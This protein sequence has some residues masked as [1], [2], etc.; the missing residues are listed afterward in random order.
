MKKTILLATAL[1]MSFTAMAERKVT[2]IGGD[3]SF[4]TI[5]RTQKDSL[6]AHPK[7]WTKVKLPHTWNAADGQDGGGNYVRGY[8]WYKKTLKVT[9]ESSKIYTLKFNGACT[10]ATVY[11]NNVE[12]G[13]HSG[14][15]S[16][17]SFDITNYL[18]NGNNEILV[19]VDNREALD[20]APVSAD[21]TFYGGIHRT[22]ELIE[23][24][25]VHIT[26]IDHAAPGVYITQKKVS[27]A[28]ADLNILAKV[29][30]ASNAN[31]AVTVTYI[32]RDAE[33]KTVATA[34]NSETIN[35]GAT[36][37]VS[38]DRKLVAPTLWNGQK[39]PY[40]YS[41]E[42]CVKDG[43]TI[44]DSV[45]QP[46]GVRDI[47]LTTDG[48]FL[49]GV[50]TPLR[51]VAI[52]EERR[53]KGRAL[54]NDD[55]KED[56]DMMIEMGC[57]YLR[58][59]HY[60]HADFTYSYCD[61]MGIMNWAEIPVI[62]KVKDT[63]EFTKTSKG[64][65]IDLIRQNYN[66]PSIVVWGICNEINYKTFE[67]RGPNPLP[68]VKALNEV[69][70][71][72][73]ATRPSVLAAM[74]GEPST[75]TNWVPDAFACNHYAGW[76]YDNC[77]DF[78]TFYDDLCAK[79]PQSIIGISEYGCGANIE[80]HEE[81]PRKPSNPGGPF[82][83]EEYQ[84][85]F[86]EVHLKA[87]ME[88]PKM[89][90]SSVWAAFDFSSDGRAEGSLPGVN[91]KGLVTQDRKVKKDA[92]FLYQAS[93]TSKPMVYLTSRRFTTREQ[94]KVNVKAYSNCDEVE[95]FV[96]GV[97]Q[98]K[99]KG[100]DRAFRWS[101]VSLKMGKNKI[102]V[103]G[104]KGDLVL[105]DSAVWTRIEKPEEIIKSGDI[106][107]NFTSSNDSL[108][109]YL[110]DRGG[111]FADRGKGYTY[112][113]KVPNFDNSRRRNAKDV[114]ERFL[115]FV[116]MTT[117]AKPNEWE[118]ALPNGKYEVTIGAGDVD[119]L[120]SYNKIDAEKVT[121]LDFAPSLDKKYSAASAIVEVLDGKLTISMNKDAKN[122]KLCF[123]NISTLK[124][125]KTKK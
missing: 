88:R 83:S 99:V 32:I 30:N 35:A 46:L 1:L 72:E 91:D 20:V 102:V 7:A 60:Q 56:V 100:V 31:K 33:G 101:D 59:S 94:E 53:D 111:V 95:L 123:V 63:E 90:C 64:Q 98:G 121:V 18:K 118:I 9:K 29:R 6:N 117:S 96:N 45:T 22:V 25:A 84:N 19:K 43:E 23:T 66:H 58:L 106:Q 52:H 70:K 73:D 115:G 108:E 47:K 37:N 34:S 125:Y 39:N 116:H 4:Y 65:L 40:L 12:V 92:Y 26:T 11:I 114:E 48:F 120:D 103:K 57:N 122:A 36:K 55:R 49:N 61:K 74:Y 79:Y 68:L 93:W 82:H 89:W 17:F 124:V 62:N 109:G 14:G 27:A 15:Y 42:V 71:S 110:A 119:Y 2:T 97:S 112:G 51:G 113:W 41:V 16:A 107:I 85:L 5:N 87:I 8:F 21:F 3:W 28:S 44:L 104:Y 76:Y 67:E 24:D 77:E 81:I 13:K 80:H 78:A 105:T 54:S 86:H 69:A 50:H 38:F 75:G 10:E